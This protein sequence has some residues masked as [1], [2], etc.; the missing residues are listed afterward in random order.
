MS[1][2][3]W[4]KDL[5]VGD[6]VI[7]HNSR[8]YIPMIKTVERITP[9]GRIVVS[10]TNFKKDGWQ[11]NTGN[12]WSRQHLEQWTEERELDIRKKIFI[13]KVLSKINDLDTLTYDQAYLIN[14][15]LDS[16]PT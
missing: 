9:T 14:E 2:E 3:Q 7:I 6:K 12:S 13:G 16:N 15:I 10:G 4:I 11:M 5:K 8:G 1:E